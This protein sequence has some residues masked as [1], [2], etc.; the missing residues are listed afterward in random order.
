MLKIFSYIKISINKIYVI[1]PFLLIV[2]IVF[3]THYRSYSE[4]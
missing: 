3:D 1:N 2:D 4:K